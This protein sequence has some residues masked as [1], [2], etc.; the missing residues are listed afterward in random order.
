MEE[1][2]AVGFTVVENNNKAANG[3]QSP[4]IPAA[5][6]SYIGQAAQIKSQI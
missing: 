4:V 5:K 1:H 6:T 3:E 2:I